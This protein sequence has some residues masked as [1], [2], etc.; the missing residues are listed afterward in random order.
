MRRIERLKY[1]QAAAY[2]WL[3]ASELQKSRCLAGSTDSDVARADMNFYV[4]AVQRL[5]EVARQAAARAGVRGA[6]TALKA[7]DT[8]WPRIKGVTPHRGT[9]NRSQWAR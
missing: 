3:K 6:Q 8:E 7:F 2:F 9:R 4:V 1:Y 5:R